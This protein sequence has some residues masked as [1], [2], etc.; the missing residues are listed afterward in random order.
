MIKYLRNVKSIKKLIVTLI[1]LILI[2]EAFVLLCGI[3]FDLMLNLTNLSIVIFVLWL[4][5][6]LACLLGAILAVQGFVKNKK[7]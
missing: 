1:V 7:K 4:I 3:I 2:P 5:L 6:A